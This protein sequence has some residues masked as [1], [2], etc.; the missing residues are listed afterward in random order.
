MLNSVR[1]L[2]LGEQ[3][4]AEVVACREAV[5][6]NCEKDELEFEVCAAMQRADAKSR[7]GAG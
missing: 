3:E 2:Q 5:G 4:E 1:L 7:G 6:S